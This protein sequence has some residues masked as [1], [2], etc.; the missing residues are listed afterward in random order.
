MNTNIPN[1][2]NN[3]LADTHT[4]EVIENKVYNKL[5]TDSSVIQTLNKTI[6]DKLIKEP[7]SINTLV[8]ALDINNIDSLLGLDPNTDTHALKQ[9][10][11]DVIVKELESILY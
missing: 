7:Q 8:N 11:R 10:L 6:T 3:I 9:A 5:L 2:I 1:E 4:Y